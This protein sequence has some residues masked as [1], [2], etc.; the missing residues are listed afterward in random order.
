MIIYILAGYAIVLF[1]RGLV[2]VLGD[3]LGAWFFTK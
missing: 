1:A 3:I 2:Y